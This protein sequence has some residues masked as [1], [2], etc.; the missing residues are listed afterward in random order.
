MGKMAERARGMPR[1]K[2]AVRLGAPRAQREGLP[3]LEE[4]AGGE[5]SHFGSCV[6]FFAGLVV[7]AAFLRR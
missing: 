7:I 4:R 3:L 2:G 1:A 5:V 6:S